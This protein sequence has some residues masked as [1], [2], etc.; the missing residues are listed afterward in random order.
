MHPILAATYLSNAAREDGA[1]G[2]A[3]GAEAAV[4]LGHGEDVADP[5][6]EGEMTARERG[7]ER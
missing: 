5:A 4:H 3:I 6:G 7:R 1:D 2:D